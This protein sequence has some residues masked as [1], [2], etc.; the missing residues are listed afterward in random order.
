MLIRLLHWL[1]WLTSFLQ[2]PFG[3]K[4][5]RFRKTVGIKQVVQPPPELTNADLEYLFTQLLEG[6]YQARGQ[7]WA[8]Q[9]LQR[10]EHRITVERWLDWLLIF[11]EKLL[12]SPAPN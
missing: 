12:A 11:G 4:K 2:R 1:K 8:L 9:Y 10:M 6:V 5:T 7:Q 3:S